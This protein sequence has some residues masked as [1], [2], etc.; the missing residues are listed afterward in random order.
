MRLVMGL[1]C[2]GSASRATV[3]DESLES[4]FHGQGGPANLASTPDHLITR[5][6]RHAVEG[7]P[8]PSVVFGCFAGLLVEDDRRRAVDLLKGLFPQADCLA[9]PD[10]A[11][12]LRASPE[13]TDACVIAGTGSLVCSRVDGKLV[14]SGG[15]GYLLGDEGSA[16]QYGLAALKQFV[17]H[18][19]EAS[20]AVRTEIEN[21]FASLDVPSVIARTYRSGTPAAT[22]AKL[23]AALASDAAGNLEYAIRAIDSQASALSDIVKN[24]IKMYHSNLSRP[25]VS[26]AGGVWRMGP[27]REAFVQRLTERSDHNV[28]VLRIKQAPVRGA[29]LLAADHANSRA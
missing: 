12:A 28:C 18:P 5:N 19:D 1:D 3:L 11:A 14:R 29:A 6:L 20:S 16:F 26:L 8:P 2:G 10:Y 21:L 13:G 4:V 23:A 22:I 17:N 15:K 9:E 25:V 27:F 24:H 7:A